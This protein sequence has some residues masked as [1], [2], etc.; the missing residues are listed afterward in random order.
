[1]DN[2]PVVSGQSGEASYSELRQFTIKEDG[3]V[4]AVNDL[5]S[6]GWRLIDIGYRADA[7]IYVLGRHEERARHRAGFLSSE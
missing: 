1:M 6:Q 3:E 5:L 2:I 7:T 4:G